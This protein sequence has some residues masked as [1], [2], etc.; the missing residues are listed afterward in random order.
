[1]V[2][3]RKLDIEQALDVATALFWSNGYDGTSLSD[4]TKAMGITPPSFYFAFGSKEALFRRVYERYR[5]GHLAYVAEALEAPTAREVGERMLY[6]GADAQTGGGHPPGC[7][8]VS[9]AS[10]GPVGCDPVRDDLIENR[11][12]GWKA[13]CERFELAVASGDLPQGTDV[14]ALAR[15]VHVVGLGMSIDA[16][17]G[18]SRDDL[19][20]MVDVA[21][22]AWPRGTSDEPS[23]GG[24]P[25]QSK[26]CPIT[27]IRRRD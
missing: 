21:M 4:L 16:Q 11:R 24:V 10:P 25:R 12:L 2:R 1:M 27:R 14:E 17:G 3:P 23:R 15:F 6:G 18:A 5:S 20:R 19:R 26:T 7:M 8:G 13:L 22:K 9:C